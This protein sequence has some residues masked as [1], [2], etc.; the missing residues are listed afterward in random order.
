MPIISYNIT[1]KKKLDDV[2]NDILEDVLDAV[3][4]KLLEDFQ[5]HL[6]NTVYKPAETDTYHRYYK[7]GGFYSGWLMK[8]I[9][10]FT[11]QLL[12]DGSRLVTPGADA[13]NDYI[14]HGG[15]DG[16]D[17]RSDMPWILNDITSNVTYSAHEGALY[18]NKPYTMRPYWDL[19]MK[20]IG[21]KVEKWFTS[22]FKKYGITRG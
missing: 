8:K 20:D 15:I 7:N 3:S 19:Y 1:S 9:S 6:D 14:A 4:Q 18:L 22:E 10:N 16:E 13:I 2:L 5:Q 12:F 11:R 21:S 17:I